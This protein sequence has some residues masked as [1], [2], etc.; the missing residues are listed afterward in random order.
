[1]IHDENE[2]NSNSNI[3]SQKNKPVSIRNW[4]TNPSML[5]TQHI[6]SRGRA[7]ATPHKFETYKNTIQLK[8]YG[9]QNT[10]L[11]VCV[12]VC[13]CVRVRAEASNVFESI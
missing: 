9:I 12:C 2:Q 11:V 6:L 13:V 10:I 7:S 3:A 1:M 8:F 5:S 4:A